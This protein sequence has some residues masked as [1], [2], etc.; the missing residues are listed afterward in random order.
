MTIKFIELFAGVGGFHLAFKHRDE[1]KCVYANDNNKFTKITYDNNFTNKLTIADI[2][3]VNSNDIPNHDVLTAG[4]PCQSFSVA[5]LK[6]GFSDVR[7]QLFF[8]IIR[9]LKDKKPEYF[10]LE[11]VR[12]LIS[13]DN[14][15]TFNIIIS[16]LNKLG[17]YIQYSVL[18]TKDFDI[19]QNR[20]RVYIIGFLNKSEFFSF[21]FPDKLTR[22]RNITDFLESDC[23]DKYYYN[24]KYLYDKLVDK[25][26]K[27]NTAYQ[28]RFGK[29]VENK[30]NVCSTLTASMSSVPII[31]DNKGIRKLT[32]RECFNLQGFP[33]DYKISGVSDSQLYRQVGNSIT[34]KVVEKIIDSIWR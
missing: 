6:K 8:E 30:S 24:G 15:N 31:I 2:R 22:T 20:E 25:V 19:P 33:I 34:V 11:N 29:V 23:D 9:I 3:T 16:E 14:G 10:I 12:N 13:H 7:G 17:Y 5:G 4:F 26:I 18:N 32:P 1:F 21:K 27:K 28:W